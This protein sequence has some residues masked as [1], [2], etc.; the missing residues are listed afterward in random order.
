MT[1]INHVGAGAKERGRLRRCL[2]LALIG[3]LAISV[4][5][6]AQGRVPDL[7]QM[8][9]EELM[10]LEI[11]SASR[12]QQRVEDVAAAVFVITNDDI[13][14]SG[15]TTIPEVLR[16]APGVDVG[17]INSNNWAVSI[18]GFNGL[19]ANK[20]L[21][22]V[23]GRSVYNRLFAGVYWDAEDLMLDDID[24]IEVIRGPG[25]AMW[26]ANAVN[27]VINIVTKTAMDTSGPLVRVDAGR[28]AEQGAV[29]YG[30]GLGAARYRVFTQWTNREE[31]QM[32][33]TV[34]AGDSFHSAT[35]GFRSDW[36]TRPGAWMLEG[37]FTTGRG[38]KLWPNFNPQ[39]AA[40]RPIADDSANTHGGHILS[41]WTHT[42]N[43][44]ASLQIQFFADIVGR[45]ETPGDYD[46][47]T[48][49]A[50]TQYRVALG[51]HH[52][53]VIGAGYRFGADT[54]R[55]HVGVSLTPDHTRSSLRTAF[56][57]DEIALVGSQLALTLGTQVQNDS[58]AGAGVQPTAR[59]MWKGVPHQRFWASASRAL[60][61]PSLYER[62][63]QVIYP[64]APGPN[65][66]SLV[67]VLKGNDAPRAE[68]LID[69]EAGYRLEIG[70]AASIDVT[71]YTGN[72]NHLQTAESAA[73]VVQFVPSPQV[74]AVSQFG[75]QLDAATHGFEF[76]GRWTPVPAWRL[77]GSYTGFRITPQL[78]AASHD[79]TAA[80][81]DGTAPR[82]QWQLRSD[83]SP[84]AQATF[85][86]GIFRVGSLE[87][88]QIPAYTRVD[89]SAEWR[90]SGRLSAMVTGQNLF[91][92]AHAEFASTSSLLLATQTPRSVGIRFRW[93]M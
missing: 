79:A 44:G 56:V 13:R 46:R 68:S 26:G 62:G 12:K 22:L 42:S 60:R 20:L 1:A 4:S 25:A 10:S 80:M 47:Q 34:R 69:T 53:L 32:A 28:L 29:R 77:N 48:F 15:L 9:I 73:P 8:S 74:L 70:K 18:R 63:I 65:G 92:A 54:Y 14:R 72:Y 11:T 85:A 21:V 24:R 6:R 76:A 50:D 93:S 66:L 52:D 91:D 59:A 82:T 45:Q 87:R 75:N 41:R 67:V 39:T 58:L 7:A 23:D 33:A 81:M 43:N 61:T 86:A 64:P 78:S 27:G 2:T 3:V 84:S 88:S 35:T 89:V 51:T 5:A 49:D 57:Q 83:F 37:A 19:Y 16:L 17:Q 71:A 30:G 90:F 36:T 31:S 38:Q 55:G 40:L